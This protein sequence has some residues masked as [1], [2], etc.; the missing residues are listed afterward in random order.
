VRAAGLFAVQLLPCQPLAL[1]PVNGQNSKSGGGGEI[2]P[3]NDC[4]A[5]PWSRQAAILVNESCLVVDCLGRAA[6]VLR[7]SAV[8]A[9]KYF[10]YEFDPPKEIKTKRIYR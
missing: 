3:R 7:D 2:G 10:F 4:S 8:Y 5:R 9:R 6:S 1:I